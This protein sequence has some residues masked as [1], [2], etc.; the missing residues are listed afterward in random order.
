MGHEL[1]PYKKSY[2]KSKKQKNNRYTATFE[3]LEK[4][5][6][7]VNKLKL[8]RKLFRVVSEMYTIF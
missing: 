3:W 8:L 2:K 4:I 6:F 1:A 5:S 7:Y